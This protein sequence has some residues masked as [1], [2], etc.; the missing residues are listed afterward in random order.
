MAGDSTVS[1]SPTG[2]A[3]VGSCGRAGVYGTPG[4]PAAGNVPGSRE[5]AVSWI[6]GGGNFWLFGGD[7]FDSIG[8]SAILN[9]LWEFNPATGLWAWM[10]G[11]KLIGQAGV[12]GTLG[13][14]AAGNVPG[15]RQ[16]AMSWIDRGGNFW[17]FGGDG[18]DSTGSVGELND[19]WEFSPSAKE[20]T[21][22]GG[23]ST[24]KQSGVY[25]TLGAPAA[26][27]V[28]GSRLSAVSWIDGS[29]NFW[30][31]G[32]SGLDST[33]TQGDLNDLWEFNPSAKTWI[34]AGGTS[35]VVCAVRCGQPGVYGTL[36]VPA[37]ANIPGG[38]LRSSAWNDGTGNFWLFG[39]FGLD[40][41]GN[42][43]WLDDLWEY[44]P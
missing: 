14:P 9:D 36:D 43:G 38:R 42:L 10:G 37:A 27:N 18:S 12:Y 1:T 33:G 35:T 34:W 41:I 32:G 22:I 8:E 11:S 3:S 20:W 39:G 23:G 25:G 21:W 13:V 31:F 40:S 26:G 24:A 30:L 4:M 16:S 6:D 28:P 44:R 19:V 5:S 7:G 15:S 2:C 29:G 17:L